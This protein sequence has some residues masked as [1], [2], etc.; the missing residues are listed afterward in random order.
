MSSI[1]EGYLQQ[2]DEFLSRPEQMWLLGAGISYQANIPLM[3]PLTKQVLNLCEGSSNIT[4]L[5]ALLNELPKGSHI[6]HLLSH[7]GDYTAIADRVSS[8][9]I[10]INDTQYGI[11]TLQAAHLEVL[12]HIAKTVR[13]GYC[14]A[15][16]QNEEKI[17]SY[18]EP[19]VTITE[20]INFIKALFEKRQAGLDN[21]RSPIRFF[22]TNYDTLL[23]DALALC[24][25]PYWDGFSGGAIAFRNYRFGDSEPEK[26]FRAH[27][28]KLHGSID[29]HLSN[30]DQVLRVRDHDLYPKK[31]DRVLIYPQA[32]KYIATQRD[33]FAAQFDIFRRSLLNGRDNILAICGYSFGDDHIN[34][35][36]EF[37]LSNSNSKTTVLAFCFE[38]D[39]LPEVLDNWRNSSFGKRIYIL[40]QNGLYVGKKGPLNMPADG[41][42]LNWWTFEGLTKLLKDG[43][44]GAI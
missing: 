18:E 6:E 17:G 16:E 41:L 14:Q 19:I 43:V 21:R 26:G 24:S 23:E 9:E 31:S 12:K 42:K 25:I 27:V 34:Q 36:I 44:E 40:T 35:E 2:V 33:P 28:I 39:G 7:L 3:A 4:L 13:W 10:T 8:K 15:N 29:W 20:H 30:D 1:D 5:K 11:D 37:A 38:S 22:T 32:T